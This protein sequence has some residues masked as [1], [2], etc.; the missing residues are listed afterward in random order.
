[1]FSLGLV[2]L[3]LLSSCRSL[4]QDL[5]WVGD[6]GEGA[7]DRFHQKTEHLFIALVRRPIYICHVDNGIVEEG[8]FVLDGG[9]GD[10]CQRPTGELWLVL[11]KGRLGRE[12]ECGEVI[13]GINY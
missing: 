10:M 2:F 7:R 12:D 5:N 13:L 1:M 11:R 3:S 6:S 9:I 4:G 8:I